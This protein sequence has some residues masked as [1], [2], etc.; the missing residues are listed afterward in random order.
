MK[1]TN[2]VEPEQ[3]TA[4]HAWRRWAARTL[5][6]LL[7]TYMTVYIA[8]L[9]KNKIELFSGKPFAFGI[10][11]VIIVCII[12]ILLNG[13]WNAACMT[14]LG[15]TAGKQLFG[16]K[17]LDSAG[18]SITFKAAFKREMWVVLKGLGLCIPI[19]SLCAQY[20]G[21]KRLEMHQ[22][23]SWDKKMHLKVRYRMQSGWITLAGV[24][25][26]LGLTIKFDTVVKIWFKNWDL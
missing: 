24:I 19:V 18:Q 9:G 25:I 21:Y 20:K 6:D 17:I 22:I 7:A 11:F 12:V 14:Y 5:D 16:I 23:T 1:N 4:V 2:W 10:I 3:V 15:N 8:Y 26:I 13:L